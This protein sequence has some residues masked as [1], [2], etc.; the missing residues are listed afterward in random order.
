MEF[1]VSWLKRRRIES[2]KVST[3]KKYFRRSRSQQ[4]YMTSSRKV[5]VILT[6]KIPPLISTQ[7]VGYALHSIQSKRCMSS[8]LFS[9][10]FVTVCYLLYRHG[11]PWR[12]H[13]ALAYPGWYSNFQA[14]PIRSVV[15][16]FRILSW[17]E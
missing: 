11:H 8:S 4:L 15:S 6:S 1:G 3:N 2:V 9:F 7:H 13:L 10:H 5:V 12:Q 16:L 17:R 14:R